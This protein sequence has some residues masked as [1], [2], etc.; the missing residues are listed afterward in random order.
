MHRH[1]VAVEVS[2]EP[3]AGQRMQHNGVTFDQYRLKGLNA[4]SMEGRRTVEQDRMLMNNFFEDIPD[5]FV[6]SFNHSLSAFNCIGQAT[7]FKFANNKRL[8]QL[9]SYFLRQTALIKFQIRA[10]HNYR[11]SRVIHT[12]TK[13]V[14]TE[15]SLLALNHIGQRFQ[16]P[17]ITAQNRTPAAAII[18]QRIH[19][20]LQ[21]P[22]LIADNHLRSIQVH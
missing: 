16:R 6:T 21:H 10:Y 18:Q 20:L 4:H 14:L 9:Q 19:R 3:P 8:I 12:L 13:Q 15:S 17:I 22:F 7:L 5:L 2:I 1:L 11:P